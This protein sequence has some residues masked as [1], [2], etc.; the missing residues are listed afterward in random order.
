MHCTQA[1]VETATL[2]VYIRYGYWVI[3]QQTVLQQNPNIVDLHL[4]QFLGSGWQVRSH[5]HIHINVIIP[6]PVLMAVT[7]C[8]SER[9][10]GQLQAHV[11]LVLTSVLVTILSSWCLSK[12][13]A[14]CYLAPPPP[15]LPEKCFS[16]ACFCRHKMATSED[17]RGKTVV[18]GKRKDKK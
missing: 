15:E 12:L 14:I 10:T 11:I 3:L 5:W 7:F 17:V 1:F 13:K 16:D 9:V 2:R 6:S 4:T 18:E 8:V